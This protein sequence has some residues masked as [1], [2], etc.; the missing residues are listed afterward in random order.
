MNKKRRRKVEAKIEFVFN[1]KKSIHVI[2]YIIQQCGGKVGEHN[3]W[4]IVFEADRYH[5]NKY[6]IPITGDTY[7]NMSFGPVPSSIYNMVKGH[8]MPRGSKSPKE[9]LQELGM[10]K[11]PFKYNK[12]THM[13]SSSVSHD[14]KRFIKTN[15]EA[16][17]RSIKRYGSLS[18]EEL[19]QENHKERCWLE[20]ERRELIPFEFI[21]ENEEVL[22]ALL[23]HPHGIAA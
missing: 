14:P 6:G 19:R 12:D 15:V 21:V 9:Y 1:G 13:L 17:D 7:R 3:L 22:A 23:V 8:H 10:A 20:T 11:L 18:I 2:L 5:L 16:L 4:R